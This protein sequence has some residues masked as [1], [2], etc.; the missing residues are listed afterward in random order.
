MKRFLSLVLSICVLLSIGLVPCRAADEEYKTFLQGDSRWGSYVYGGGCNI[1]Y[2]GCMITSISVLMAYSD[3]DRRD[4]NKWTPKTCAQGWSFSGS[5]IIWG[6]SSF[7]DFKQANS[8][9]GDK[10][11]SEEDAKKMIKEYADKG[12]YIVCGGDFWYNGSNHGHY[13][14]VV[15]ISS[16]GTPILWDVG[17][18]GDGWQPMID[19]T[20]K[21]GGQGYIQI[22]AYESSKNDSKK[23]IFNGSLESGDDIEYDEEA[24][25]EAMGNM[26]AEQELKGL[27]DFSGMQ[28]GAQL[29]FANREDLSFM[30]QRKIAELNENDTGLSTVRIVNIMLM[31]AG[32]LM[33]LYS[34]LL[35][36]SMFFDKVNNLFDFQLVSLMTLGRVTLVNTGETNS[37]NGDKKKGLVS[38]RTFTTGII[39]VFVMGLL[40]VS[41]VFTKLLYFIGLW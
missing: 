34:S 21:H 16:D 36:L 8:G 26:I 17:W 15:G 31:V 39:I 32:I 28:P 20:F 1:A 29:N 5:A 35:V 40:L 10:A 13:S 3:P 27:P 19:G 12:W 22:V 4:V 7:S 37:D 14:P 30:E 23:T 41:G 6:G 9:N 38:V 18:G 11:P 33:L 2:S 24:A 25:A